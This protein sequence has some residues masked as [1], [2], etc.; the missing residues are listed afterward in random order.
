MDESTIVALGRGLDD[1]GKNT[2]VIK[3]NDHLLVLNAF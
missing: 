1:T 2:C 3:G